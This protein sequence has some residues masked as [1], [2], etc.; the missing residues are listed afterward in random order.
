MYIVGKTGTGK[1][2]FLSNMI[3]SDMKAGN[4]LCLLDPHGELVDSVLEH[5]PTNRINDV[6][7]FDV[8]D[9]DFPI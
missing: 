8:S 2:V 4:G 6:I 7:M 5:I 1:S 3:I 9:S